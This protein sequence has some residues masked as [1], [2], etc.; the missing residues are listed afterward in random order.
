[1][2]KM[3]ENGGENYIV[4]YR[5]EMKYSKGNNKTRIKYVFY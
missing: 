4:Y 1:M 2:I 3:S 5:R